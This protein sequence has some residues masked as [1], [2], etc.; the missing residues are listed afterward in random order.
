MEGNADYDSRKQKKLEIYAANNLLGRLIELTPTH[1]SDL[2]SEL[3]KQLLKKA[4]ISV[5]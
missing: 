3:A 2:E 4:K 1:Q 5:V